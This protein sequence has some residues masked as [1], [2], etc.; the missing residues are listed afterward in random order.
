M[1][2]ILVLTLSAV[3]AFAA[4]AG[5][6][7]YPA[8][9]ITILMGSAAGS[10]ADSLTRLIGDHLRR[11][12]GQPVLVENKPGA[13]GNISAEAVAKA[14]P[15]GYTLLLSPNI[16]YTVAPYMFKNLPFD[17][18]KD[19][20]PI[21]TISRFPFVLV[22]APDR[23]PV[24][25]VTELTAYLKA[26]KNGGMVGTSSGFALASTEQYKSLAG[27]TL[28]QVP[29]RSMAQALTDLSAGE[30]DFMFADS[31]LAVEQNQS[32]KYRALAVTAEQ[33]SRQAPNVP[34]MQEAGLNGFL[35]IAGWFAL[36]GPAGLPDTIADRLNQ[37]TA[38]IV[39]SEEVARFLATTNHEPFPGSRQ[40][41]AKL[42]KR[43]LASWGEIAKI[44]KLEVQ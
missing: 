8:K 28:T 22:V 9:P 5:A 43:E 41:M 1:F 24:N 15:D 33:R 38:T 21:A 3:A 29:Y 17:P 44:A 30:I 40:D 23:V 18:V 6:Q 12:V 37:L 25:S 11:L 16:T 19:F 10:N 34:T 20:T 26:K 27:L 7:D 13:F 35:P 42:Q 14:R 32:R 36:A 39:Q 4:Q 2:R 31:S